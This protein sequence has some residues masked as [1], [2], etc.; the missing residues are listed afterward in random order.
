MAKVLRGRSLLFALGFSAL[1]S[2]SSQALAQHPSIILRDFDGNPI[3]D[4]FNSSDSITLVYSTGGFEVLYSGKPVSFEKS[5]ATGKCHSG[6]I[7]EVRAGHHIAIG[8][9]DYPISDDRGAKDFV[10]NKVLR[11]RYFR[12][13]SHY[14]GW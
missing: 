10:A 7:D 12:S 4:S 11:M 3:Y 6:I 5:C 14:G 1:V 9:H 8:L 13:K 2:F